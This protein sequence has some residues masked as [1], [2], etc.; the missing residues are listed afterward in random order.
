MACQAG[1]YLKQL[2]LSVSEPKLNCYVDV[3]VLEAVRAATGDVLPGAS[4]QAGT[5]D[6]V[7][8]PTRTGTGN[9]TTVS[10]DAEEIVE[11]ESIPSYAN[12]ASRRPTPS[13]F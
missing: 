5:G 11:D 10:S 9:S 4:L 1:D 13:A 2:I 6:A 7:P 3:D 12:I 8:R